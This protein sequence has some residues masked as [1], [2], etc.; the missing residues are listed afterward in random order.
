M[1]FLQIDSDITLQDLSK[2][3]GARNIDILLNANQLQRRPDIGAQFVKKIND[4]AANNSDVHWQRKSTLLNTLVDDSDVY[5]YAACMSEN[6]WKAFSSLNTFP[7]MLYVPESIQLPASVD[8]LGNGEH[9]AKEIFNKCVESLASEQTGHKIDPE[10]FNTYASG[11]YGSTR[12]DVTNAS[13]PI[14]WFNLP[15]GKISLYS[16]IDGEMQD[17]PVYPE[18]FNDGR[19]ANYEQMP[20][21]LYQY[22]PWQVYKSSGPRNVIYRFDMHRDMWSGDHRDGKCDDLIDFCFANCYPEYKGSAV[23]PPICSMYLNGK[24]N[25]RGVITNVNPS[26]DGPIGIDGWYL[27]CVLEIQMIEVADEAL[28]Y[29]TVRNRNKSTVRTI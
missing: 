1:K 8:T 5:E 3:V 16:S 15:W 12:Y 23:N 29:H 10:I 20:E 22:E 2:Q 4:I 28:N 19:S 14:Q 7:G 27:H 24:L 9:V 21:M 11:T 18:E 6:S 13:N 17:F 25:C 26:W